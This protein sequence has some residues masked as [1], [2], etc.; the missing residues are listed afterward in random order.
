M[1]ISLAP[2]PL[3]VPADFATDKLKGAFFNGLLNTIY[4]LWTT[5]YNIRTTAK[6]QT[7]DATD[8]G[9]LR[10]PTETDKSILI[11]ARIIARRNS[12][13]AG[14]S[15][16]SAWYVLTGGYKNIGGTVSVIGSP[17]LIGGEDQAGWNVG[18][19]VSADE[20]VVVVRGAANNVVTWEATIST[21]VAGV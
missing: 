21:Y 12:G 19:S 20:V 14:S 13:S 17:D 3:N 5:V 9:I 7:T 8:T 2:P 15:G 16:D 1:T 11:E 4:Q 6:V 18:F 10:I